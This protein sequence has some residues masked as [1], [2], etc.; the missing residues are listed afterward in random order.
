MQVLNRIAIEELES[1][2]FGD[3][4]ALK[5]AYPGI[6][7]TLDKKSKYRNPDAIERTWEAL[8][9]LASI[10]KSRLLSRRFT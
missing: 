6:P 1:W 4:I 5:T 10:A 3:G 7:E 8:E 9:R 2:F